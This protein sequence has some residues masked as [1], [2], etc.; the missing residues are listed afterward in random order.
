MTT[1]GP[2]NGGTFAN[3]SLGSIYQW[4]T[5]SNAQYSDNIYSTTFSDSGSDPDYLQAT[6]FSFAIPSDATITG[7]TV[8]IEKKASSSIIVD[9]IVKL[10]KGGTISGDNKASASVWSTSDAYTTY[11]GSSDMW[12]LSLTPAD[13]NASNFGVVITG[14]VNTSSSANMYVDH[15]EI[16]VDYTGGSSSNKGFFF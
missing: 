10:V 15:I 9:T 4:A 5:P 12:G 2:N 13:V 1:V 6:N 3:V 16:T 11:G 14:G 7:I 8:G